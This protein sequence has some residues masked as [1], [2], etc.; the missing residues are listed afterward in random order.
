M[1]TGSCRL[2]QFRIKILPL[3]VHGVVRFAPE[4]FVYFILGNPF[5][6]AGRVVPFLDGGS[7]HPVPDPATLQTREIGKP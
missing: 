5:E 2:V 1:I 4:V 7:T 3:V 6:D